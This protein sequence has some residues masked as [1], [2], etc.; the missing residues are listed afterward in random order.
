MIFTF[1][2]I[3]FVSLSHPG[4]QKGSQSQILALF[5]LYFEKK[6]FAYF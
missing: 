5:Y 6:I 2:N 3:R 1:V 4:V